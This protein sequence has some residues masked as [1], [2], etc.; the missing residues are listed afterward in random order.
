VRAF[1]TTVDGGFNVTFFQLDLSAQFL[2]TIDMQIN[3]T[4]TDGATA[5]Q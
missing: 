1:Q 3:R 5:R 4:R 2:Q